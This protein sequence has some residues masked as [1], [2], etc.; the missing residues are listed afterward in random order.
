M[1]VVDGD[2]PCVFSL[3]DV[4]RKFYLPQVTSG[5]VALTPAQ[6]SIC[7]K[8]RWRRPPVRSY[9]RRCGFK[10]NLFRLICQD[11]VPGICAQDCCARDDFHS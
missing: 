4:T 10:T 3:N 8:D 11:F 2:G 7:V 1:V 9:D 6:L 5:T